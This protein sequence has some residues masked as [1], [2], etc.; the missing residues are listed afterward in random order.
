MAAALISAKT[1][2]SAWTISVALM[3]HTHVL[4]CFSTCFLGST[5]GASRMAI[6]DWP[7][8]KHCNALSVASF[9]GAAAAIADAAAIAN[10]AALECF[11]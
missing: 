9:V 2:L 10:A 8:C 3:S 11:S 6:L 5:Q 1:D 4:I 7:A